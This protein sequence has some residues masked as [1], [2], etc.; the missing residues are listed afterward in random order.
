MGVF[1][2]VAVL[3]APVLAPVQVQGEHVLLADIV[4]GAPAAI[5][6]LRIAPAPLPGQNKV[7]TRRRV[8]RRLA[9]AKASRRGLAIPARVVVTRAS[10]SLDEVALASVLL[11]RVRETAPESVQIRDA[12][13]RGAL[14][15]PA[16]EIGVDVEWPRRPRGRT[17][18]RALISVDGNYA[19]STLVTVEVAER[20]RSAAIE[21]GDRVTVIARVG[22]VTVRGVGIA[23]SKARVGQVVRVL[24]D[25]AVR[26]V[27]GQV[28]SDGSVEVRP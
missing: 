23:Q 2:A 17:T 3:S 10:Q 18:V 12:R 24:P 14:V 6:R 19:T 26:V 28:R 22:S 4:V 13:V 20:A 5:A 1:V 25:R 15:L 8:R 11:P 21:R 7:I 16:G 9:E 27:E